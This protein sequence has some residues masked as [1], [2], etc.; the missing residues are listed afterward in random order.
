MCAMTL[1]YAIDLDCY[2]YPRFLLTTL[3]LATSI[4]EHYFNFSCIVSIFVHHLETRARPIFLTKDS[5][6]L[7]H[8][9]PYF[10][11]IFQDLFSFFFLFFF[12][13][14][15]FYLFFFFSIFFFPSPSSTSIRLAPLLQLDPSAMPNRLARPSSLT[16]C[17]WSPQLLP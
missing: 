7:I 6:I 12:F 11:R 10:F 15:S 17:H 14:F 2:A 5:K 4:F 3:I 1:K 8:L 13:S 9:H 16:S